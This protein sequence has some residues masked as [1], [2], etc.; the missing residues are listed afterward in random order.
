MSNL[1]LKIKYKNKL[2]HEVTKSFENIIITG[3]DLFVIQEIF[4]D[5]SE[6]NIFALP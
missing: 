6:E 3:N 2:I 4:S 5:D 1:N